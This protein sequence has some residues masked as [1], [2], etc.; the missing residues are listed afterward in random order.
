MLFEIRRL[1]SRL[2]SPLFLN[3]RLWALVLFLGSHALGLRNLFIEIT[4]RR[5]VK[6]KNTDPQV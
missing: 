6:N 5:D 2:R 4:P 3:S 1:N